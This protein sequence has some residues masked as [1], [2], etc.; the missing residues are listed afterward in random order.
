[1]GLKLCVFPN[2]PIEAY[3]KKGEIKERYFNPTDLFDEVH[4][5]TLDEN[6]VSGEKVKVLAGSAEF[7]IHTT[8]KIN[9]RNYRK[10]KDKVLDMVKEIKPDV[11]RA[12]NPLVAGW[13][14]TYC[15][16][17]T[18]IPLVVSLHIEYDRDVRHLYS[19]DKNY[20]QLA[21][22]L[23]TGRFIEP[24][25]LK[26]ANK[27]ICAYD[28]MVDY[29]KKHGAKDVQVIYN[30]VDLK[31]FS[32]NVSP[33]LKFDKRTII[34][35]GRL[36]PEKNQECL[37]RA[38]KGLDVYLLLIGDGPLYDS[39]NQLAADLGVKDNVIFLRSVQNSEIHR[40]Y[41]SADIF[42]LPM[43]Y[44]GIAIPMLEAMASGLPVIMGKNEWEE[45]PAVIGDVIMVIDN[46]PTGFRDAFS[47]L[48]SDPDKMREMTKNGLE[49]VKELDGS[50]MEQKEATLYKELLNM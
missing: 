46:T 37:I 32:P 15:S 19:K 21:K 39:L 14:A 34:C 35:V 24:Y 50:I 30:R 44:G 29:A 7:R 4:V 33:A 2:D 28:F 17:K 8:G 22:F 41:V 12:Y 45:K 47:R 10:E 40:Y 49:K 3:Y 43:K 25:V 48:L 16:Q 23:F 11:I 38:I 31:R 6:D 18:G 13:L 20:K 36:I 9:L 1:M 5:I 42:A 26:N 27:V